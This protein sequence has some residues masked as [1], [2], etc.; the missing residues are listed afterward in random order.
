MLD[1]LHL[2]TNTG[3]FSTLFE[4]FYQ[5]CFDTFEKTIQFTLNF[6][7]RFCVTASLIGLLQ[8]TKR[9]GL[10]G[11]FL[12]HLSKHILAYARGKTD[13][14]K[15]FFAKGGRFGFL[16]GRYIAVDGVLLAPNRSVTE[17]DQLLVSRRGVASPMRDGDKILRHNFSTRGATLGKSH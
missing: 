12:N 14:C 3:L 16:H 4:H 11:T 13:I 5:S 7:T 9:W 8:K 2:E 1:W 10:I 15:Y 17:V 6:F